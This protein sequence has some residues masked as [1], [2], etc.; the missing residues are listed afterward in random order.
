MKKTKLLG[1]LI[2]ILGL[3]LAQNQELLHAF[4]FVTVC[5]PPL[6]TF[7]DGNPTYDISFPPGGG[8]TC[9]TIAD[10]P[11]VLL[12]ANGTVYSIKVDM[13]LTDPTLEIG[14]PYVW[15]PVSEGADKDQIKQIDSS[16]C[17]II[18]SYP[19]G[20]NPSRTF[21]IPG[22]DVWV[23]NRDSGNVTKLSPLTGNNLAGGTCGDG[24]CGTD[25]TIYSCLADCSGSMCGPA[26]TLD[27][28]EYEVIG[29]F[30]TGVGPRGV[31]GDVSGNVWVGNRDS[32]NISKLD[33][34]TGVKLIADIP[35]GGGPY[36][37]VGDAF[38]HIWISNRNAGTLQCLD[39]TTGI[40][41]AADT[42]I[43]P[44]G[45]GMGKDGSVYIASYSGGRVYRYNPSTGNCPVGIASSAT[46]N[47]GTANGARGVAVDQND[48]VWIANS[49]DNRFYVF[50]DS[51]TS[52]SVAPGGGNLIG[53]AID[54]DGFGWTVSYTSGDVYKYDFDGAS[55]NLQ[56]SV[57]I[58]G[59]PYNYSDMTGLR[60]VPKSIMIGGASIPLSAG[61]T[62]NICTDGT[63]TCTDPVP[64]ASITTFLTAC[65]PN[66][67]GD[68]EVP[69]EIFSMQFGDYT[70][71][72]LEIIY[73]KQVP[74]TTG[75]IIPCGRAWDDPATAW[76]DTNSCDFCYIVMLLNQIMNFL[77]KIAG[78]IA[79]LAIIVTG[80]LFITSAGNSERKN[81]AK[82][83]LKWI[84]V[85]FLILFLSWLIADFILSA[86]GYL[87]PLGG[88]WS[89]VCD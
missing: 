79:I 60:T 61:G 87:D 73:G 3:F 55:L 8:T 84:I 69:L 30:A 85:G 53:A 49:G 7:H 72:N 54:F 40:L 44:Y 32:G 67:S 68:C 26:G 9:L 58:N 51:T 24:L 64:C 42:V 66:A 46:Y 38:G 15:V 62:F 4:N 22:G 89:V 11:K 36:G 57:N 77:I 12:P 31:T 25:E 39:S 6:T 2:I 34:L 63:G 10:C 47:T 16:N 86:W 71:K 37:I 88:Q 13:E 56:C 21:V 82:T 27:C 19:T 1:S 59:N 48:Y 83:T 23:G 78:A 28:R 33:S 75:G 50:T 41:T 20:D 81:N 70:L 35:T 52:F 29:N 76:D 74:V 80:F 18:K 65:T 14:T 17:N 5:Q 45:I 43:S